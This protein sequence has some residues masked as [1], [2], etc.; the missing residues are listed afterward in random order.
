[1]CDE[2][3]PKQKNNVCANTVLTI[4]VLILL[5]SCMSSID[6]LAACFLS[7]VLFPAIS[8]A[9]LINPNLWWVDNRD[10]LSVSLS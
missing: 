1:M 2:E 6:F 4:L 7:H 3:N 9:S 10:R 5:S 8:K